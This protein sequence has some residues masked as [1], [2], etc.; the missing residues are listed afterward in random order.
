MTPRSV[1]MVSEETLQVPISTDHQYHS[2]SAHSVELESESVTGARV[3]DLT[4]AL[5]RSPLAFG[6]ASALPGDVL[7][8]RQ[9]FD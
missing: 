1:G 4:G 6:R 9:R 2:D 5:S 7:P 8:S 3:C